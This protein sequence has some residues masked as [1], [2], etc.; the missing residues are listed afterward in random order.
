MENKGS[1]NLIELLVRIPMFRH[2][3]PLDCKKLLAIC[4]EISFAKGETIFDIGDPGTK[5]VIM[6]Q[7]AVSIQTASGKEFSRLE[8]ADTIGDME[9]VSAQSRNARA[10]ALTSVSGM[11]IFRHDLQELFENEPV[12]GVKVL[13][14]IV[15]A[16]AR[17]LVTANLKLESLE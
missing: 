3:V 16:L 12:I 14:N 8:P 5:L 10:V 6:L 17:K 11:L 9:I 13:K 4:R 1:K 15:E 7:G 2:L